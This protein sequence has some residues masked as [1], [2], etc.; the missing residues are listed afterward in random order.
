VTDAPAQLLELAVWA[1]QHG[2]TIAEKERDQ[3]ANY[4]KLLEIWST[5][6]A[7]IA[8]G[9][10]PL[11]VRK[12]LAD[13][14]YA[15]SAC[16]TTG[17]AADLGSGAGLPGIPVAIARPDLHVDLVES[18]SKKVSFLMQ[19]TQDLA[20]AR[21]LGRRAET[22]EPASYDIVLARALAP[23]DRLLPVS[24]R[25]LRP[26]GVVLAMKSPS[27]ERELTRIDPKCVGL[28][29]ADILPY[30]LPSGESRVLLRFTSA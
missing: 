29:L 8:V 7:L 21:P 9:D 26:G 16:P 22:L 12:H 3:L 24:A 28:V 13:C 27:F 11:V 1:G 18:R 30:D 17:R 10:E 2:L 14:L 5:K 23:L 15:A 20:N 4:L 6:L 19:A 25:L